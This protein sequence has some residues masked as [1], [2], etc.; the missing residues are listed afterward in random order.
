MA[1]GSNR[2]NIALLFHDYHLK[3]NLIYGKI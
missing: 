2:Q 3:N 1:K